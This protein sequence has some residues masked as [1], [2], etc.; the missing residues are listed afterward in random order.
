MPR[1]VV[2]DLF[3]IPAGRPLVSSNQLPQ[4]LVSRPDVL[5]V[6]SV[7]LSLILCLRSVPVG[8]FTFGL[9]QLSRQC[10]AYWV[11]CGC[12]L[13]LLLCYD[14][15]WALI[16]F[17]EDPNVPGFSFRFLIL[18]KE[19]RC[20]ASPQS[21]PSTPPSLDNCSPHV[22]SDHMDQIWK[23]LL[24]RMNTSFL[25]RRSKCIIPQVRN[26]PTDLK[27]SV[28]DKCSMEIKNKVSCEKSFRM[29]TRFGDVPCN[30]NELILLKMVECCRH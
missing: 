17:F 24:I 19:R 22:Q 2:A 26:N 8:S 6:S 25:H 12:L 10:E 16:L 21:G 23:L 18:F 13:K 3:S 11:L 1:I 5:V 29:E 7:C 20:F 9:R 27:V 15:F 28:K 14:A 4:P 30:Q